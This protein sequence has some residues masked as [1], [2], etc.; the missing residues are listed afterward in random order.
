M[1]SISIAGDT[2]GAVALAAPAVA[3]TNTMTLLA[4]TGNLGPKVLSNAQASTSGTFIDFTNIPSWVT[5]ITV[6]FNGVSLSGTTNFLFQVGTSALGVITT[7]YNSGATSVSVATASTTNGSASNITN[8][9]TAAGYGSTAGSTAYGHVVF[10]LISGNSWVASGNFYVNGA[11]RT[12]TFAGA[13]D[14]A[15]ALDRVRITTVNGTDTFDAG[16]I[17]ILYE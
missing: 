17:N 14:L 11:L 10:T 2:S 13:I 15:S 4:A 8:G 12:C 6:I 3:G 5:R 7:G 9:I 1:S 16:S